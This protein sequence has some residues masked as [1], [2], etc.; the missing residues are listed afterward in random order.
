[1][2]AQIRDEDG[3]PSSADAEKPPHLDESVRRIGRHGRAT[4]DAA[5]DSG[6]ALRRL[7]FADLALARS[8]LGRAL[9]WFAV[10]I[11][12]GAS[13]WLLAMGAL[14]ALLQAFGM[15]WLGSI[16]VAGLISLLVTG[17]AAWRVSRFFEYAGLHATRRQL[18]RIGIGDEGDDEPER[19]HRH[20]DAPPAAEAR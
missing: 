10:A 20:G 14:I 4:V 9:A 13:A 8:A 7:V 11:V 1:V 5:L 2:N 19:A 3:A 12:F 16:A 15:S 17:F 6:R 18:A